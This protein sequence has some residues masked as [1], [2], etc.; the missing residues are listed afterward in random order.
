[1]KSPTTVRIGGLIAAGI[2]DA[3]ASSVTLTEAYLGTNVT[4]TGGPKRFMFSI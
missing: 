2:S 1:M 3:D 4:I